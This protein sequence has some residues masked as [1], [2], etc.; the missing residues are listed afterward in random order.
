MSVVKGGSSANLLVKGMSTEWG[1]K[2]YGRTLL[3]N[4]AQSIYKDRDA[5]V[6]GLR[7]SVRQQVGARA[8]RR[9]SGI[10]HCGACTEST[11]RG[12]AP[13]PRI[14]HCGACTESTERGVAGQGATAVLA[15]LVLS[16]TP[17][18]VLTTS[19]PRSCAWAPP[20]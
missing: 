13:P 8:H 10:L 17:L 3:A 18:R 7:D 4:I 2:L 9:G 19:P 5:I 14:L 16:H 20:R 12:G 15:H 11:E 6:K 1:K